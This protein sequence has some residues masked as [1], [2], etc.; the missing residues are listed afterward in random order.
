[1]IPP[2]PAASQPSVNKVTVP[3]SFQQIHVPGNKFHYIRLA[4]PPTSGGKTLAAMAL[5]LQVLGPIS[6][7]SIAQIIK[8]VVYFIVRRNVKFVVENAYS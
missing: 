7:H 8:C 2:K 3:S 4:A 1:M 6:H 5:I